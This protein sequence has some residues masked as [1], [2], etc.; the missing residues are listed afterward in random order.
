MDDVHNGPM[1]GEE[2]DLLNGQSQINSE[3]QRGMLGHFPISMSKSCIPL[4]IIAL[5]CNSLFV[6]L[7]YQHNASLMSFKGM[8]STKI[9]CIWNA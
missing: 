8:L 4:F 9:L 1:L 6:A 5:V 3:R 2:C 7:Y